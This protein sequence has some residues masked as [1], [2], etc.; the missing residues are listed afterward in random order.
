MK[1]ININRINVA[2][3]FKTLKINNNNKTIAIEGI[4]LGGNV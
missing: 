2:I 3:L 1:N 4:A